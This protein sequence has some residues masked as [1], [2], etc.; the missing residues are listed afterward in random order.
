MRYI[1]HANKTLHDTILFPII[2][3]IPKIYEINIYM[4][5]TTI[6]FGLTLFVIKALDI[7]DLK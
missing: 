5:F 4:N 2:F 7:M 3:K 1:Y 6:I